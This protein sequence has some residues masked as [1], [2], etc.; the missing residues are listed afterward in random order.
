M[1]L[2]GSLTWNPAPSSGRGPSLTV[3]HTV[4]AS[5]AD[6]MHALLGRPTLAGLAAT[7]DGLD[8]R[9]LDLRAGYDLGADG[10]RFTATPEVGLALQPQRRE[11]RL[12]WRLTLAG[13]GPAAFELA[14]TGT[15]A[16]HLNG[17]ENGI[18]MRMAAHW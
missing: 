17:P 16:E 10:G 5:A 6:G 15:R 4:G 14:V 13:G 12:G 3:T 2:V 8:S 11:C 18:G 9:R 7:S 1:G